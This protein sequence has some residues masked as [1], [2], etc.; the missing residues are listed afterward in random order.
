MKFTLPILLTLAASAMALKQEPPKNQPGKKAPAAPPAATLQNPPIGAQCY[1]YKEKQLQW[2]KMA[3][4]L[5]AQGHGGTLFEVNCVP[6]RDPAI[7]C[8]QPHPE[9]WCCPM[10]QDVVKG[11]GRECSRNY[12]PRRLQ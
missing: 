3:C 12:T 9:T 5:G 11:N 1:W 7:R 6:P 2:G 10:G 8:K 4:C